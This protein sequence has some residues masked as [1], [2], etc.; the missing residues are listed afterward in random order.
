MIDLVQKQ[1]FSGTV[2]RSIDDTIYFKDLLF[3]SKIGGTE[4]ICFLWKKGEMLLALYL[5]LCTDLDEEN[6]DC[7]SQFII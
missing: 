7:L 3:L 5:E 6:L 1:T 4:F 2:D